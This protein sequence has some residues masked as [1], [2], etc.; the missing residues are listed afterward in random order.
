MR[1]TVMLVTALAGLVVCAR[2]TTARQATQPSAGKGLDQLAWMV[3]SW[4]VDHG[5]VHVE[6]QIVIPVHGCSRHC[7]AWVDH[8]REGGDLQNDSLANRIQDDF[9][10]FMKVKLL[11]EVGPVRFDG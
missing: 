2:T 8:P 6:E 11:H 3:G 1:K 4:A 7:R 10:G 9:R 5:G